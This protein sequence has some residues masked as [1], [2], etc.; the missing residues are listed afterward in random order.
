[1]TVALLT[2][3]ALVTAIVTGALPQLNVMAPPDVTAVLSA[4]YVQLAAVPVPTT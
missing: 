3:I 4:L 1:M 2:V